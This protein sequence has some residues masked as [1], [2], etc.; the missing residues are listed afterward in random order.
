MLTRC[1]YTLK[2]L[3]EIEETSRKHIIL[4][5]LGGPDGYWVAASKAENN[6]F[7]RTVDAAFQA[8][9][10]VAMLCSK[11]GVKTRSG[12]AAWRLPG[13]LVDGNRPV[14]V[15]IPHQGSAEVFHRKPV[16]KDASGKSFQIIAPP[17]Q[18]DKLLQE[19]QKNL[20]KKGISIS[21]PITRQAPDQTIHSQ[22]TTNFTV[23]NA[24]LM[25]IAYLAC[26]ELLGDSFLK[27]PLNPEWQKAIRAKTA[28][29][30]EAVK[31][32]GWCFTNATHFAKDILPPLA[33]HEHGIAILNVN[34]QGIIVA[35]RLFGCELLTVVAQ[36]SETSTHGLPPKRGELLLCDARGGA[37]RRKQ[38]IVDGAT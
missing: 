14:E 5:S 30:I 28:A 9:P 21:E 19:M 1:P 23:L 17:A 6:E 24:G 18:A 35:V 4:D 32:H 11:V 36:P 7:G 37:I 3:A 10:L 25:K 20:A 16:D 2:P 27:D 33:E 34:H 12:V 13:E 38:V 31:I 8:E 29:Q 26:C 22:L 15:T